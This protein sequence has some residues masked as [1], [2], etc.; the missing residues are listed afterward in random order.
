MALPYD[1]DSLLAALAARAPSPRPSTA[2][3]D[4]FFARFRD[5]H[6]AYAEAASQ[7]QA[8]RDSAAALQAKLDRLPRTAPEYRDG[9]TAFTAAARARADAEAR[10]ATAEKARE[11]TRK[12]LGSRAEAER[13]AIK[14]WEDSTYQNY[15]QITEG[16]SRGVGR[17]PLTDTTAAGGRAVLRLGPGR[18][19]IYA[20]AWD[21]QDPNAEWYW[22]VPVEGDSVVLSPAN[23]R[24]VPRY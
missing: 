24:R 4:S 17:T 5:A 13:A 14:A 12:G 1:R 6:L 8:L 18:W 11:A 22:N 9:Y 15:Q 20:R 23:A 19:W 10:L 2:A 7:A 3:I 21:V 16:L